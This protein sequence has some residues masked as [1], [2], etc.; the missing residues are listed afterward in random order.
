MNTKT[1]LHILVFLGICFSANIAVA[2]QKP[3]VVILMADDVGWAALQIMCLV[4]D[5]NAN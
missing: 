2:D 1:I 5:L 4:I 3:N